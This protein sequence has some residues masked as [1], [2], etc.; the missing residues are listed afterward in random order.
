[1]NS[2][3]NYNY[4]LTRDQP[5]QTDVHVGVSA[6]T[7]LNVI[8]EGYNANEYDSDADEQYPEIELAPPAHLEGFADPKSGQSGPI[9][10]PTPE[11][12]NAL[13]INA[14]TGYPFS[15]E[16]RVGSGLERQL[17]KVKYVGKHGSKSL[18]YADEDAYTRC[19]YKL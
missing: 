3:L 7:A 6:A 10:H 18:F 13:I 11:R 14:A 17:F 1:M 19:M 16:F 8:S 2:F 5:A 15:D 9:R 4:G 12:T